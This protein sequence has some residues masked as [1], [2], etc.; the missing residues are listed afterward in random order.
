MI[1]TLLK[2]FLLP[3]ALQLSMVLV[4][5]LAW[6]RFRRL[7]LFLFTVAWLSL[8]LLSL[9][10]VSNSLFYWL[11]AP[12]V[13]HYQHGSRPS[14]RGAAAVVVLGAGRQ[15]KPLEYTDDQPSYHALWRLRYGFRLARELNLPLITSGGTVYPYETLSEAQI[16]A[17]VLQ[18]DY[19]FT[20]VIQ[21]GSSRNTWQ[22]AQ[23]TA[24]LAKEV[25]FKQV[26]LVTHAYHM[27]R[28]ELSFNK[29][30]LDVIAMPT[31]FQSSAKKVWWDSGLPNAGALSQSR[32]AI[33][34]YLGLI[35]YALRQ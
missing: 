16:A 31:G 26:I 3:P 17:T 7:A 8:W 22:N 13:E 14:L 23:N 11:E 30:G 1:I 20:N 21:E 9:P 6:R 29:A 12:Y 4:A 34:E 27:R 25:G 33:H 2:T 28:S 15:R 5:A 24:S 19:G 10:L 18:E 35:F 32:T